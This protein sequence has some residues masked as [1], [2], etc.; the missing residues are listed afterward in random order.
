MLMVGEG[1][2]ML[3][4]APAYMHEGTRLLNISNHPDCVCLRVL[5]LVHDC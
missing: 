3:A 4:A 5:C 2:P 1:G